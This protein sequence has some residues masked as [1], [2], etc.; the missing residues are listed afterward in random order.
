MAQ[1][2]GITHVKCTNK[3][4]VDLLKVDWITG[5]D[6]DAETFSGTNEDIVEDNMY[7]EEENGEDKKLEADGEVNNNKLEDILAGKETYITNNMPDENK[8]TSNENK[9]T[10]ND[11]SS[12]DPS[13]ES[14]DDDIDQLVN[15]IK[16][17]FKQVCEEGEALISRRPVRERKPVDR[18]TYS[19]M[20]QGFI[21][22]E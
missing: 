18:L 17:D 10:S 22:T 13:I 19:S 6:Y 16:N 12:N 11:E 9:K 3:K 2:K 21:N 1:E 14:V 4:E 7:V 8:K 15:K 5:V 20:L